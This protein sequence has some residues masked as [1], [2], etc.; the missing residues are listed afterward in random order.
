MFYFNIGGVMKTLGRIFTSS[1]LLV[2]LLF[3]LSGCPTSN[4]NPLI[5]TWAGTGTGPSFVSETLTYEFTD[6]T[7]TISGTV[8]GDTWVSTFTGSG[9]YTIDENTTTITTTGTVTLTLVSG[10]GG[11]DGPVD[12]SGTAIYSISGNTL[13]IVSSGPGNISTA[14][15]TR[16]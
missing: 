3:F 10:S 14:T 15:L 1:V 2:G 12:A 8:T 5:G 9:T 7:W 6:D 13:T 16:Q 11:P 4:S